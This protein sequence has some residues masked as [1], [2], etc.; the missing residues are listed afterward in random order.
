VRAWFGWVDSS[1]EKLLVM[2]RASTD[3]IFFYS[4]DD[5]LIFLATVRLSHQSLGVE[6][7]A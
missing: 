3:F 2:E 6:I 5:W 4:P 1:L 7:H